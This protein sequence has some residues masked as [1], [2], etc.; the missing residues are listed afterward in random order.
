MDEI[1]LEVPVGIAV[2]LTGGNPADTNIGRFTLARFLAPSNTKFSGELGDI[3][4]IFE[5]SPKFDLGAG[6]FL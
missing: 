6:F 5:I 3:F 2:E 4:V 1:I